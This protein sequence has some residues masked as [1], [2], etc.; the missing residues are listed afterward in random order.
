MMN[1]QISSTATPS[2]SNVDSGMTEGSMGRVANFTAGVNGAALKTQSP[3]K[4]PV[5]SEVK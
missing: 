5:T 3:T 4:A 2:V 1:T